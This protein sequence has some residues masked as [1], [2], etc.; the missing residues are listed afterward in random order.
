LLLVRPPP[1][2]A[3]PDADTNRLQFSASLGSYV[4]KIPEQPLSPPPRPPPRL[5]VRSGVRLHRRAEEVVADTFRHQRTNRRCPRVGLAAVS[6]AHLPSQFEMSYECLRWS[7]G[8]VPTEGIGWLL[9]DHGRSTS[10][11]TPNLD[12]RETLRHWPF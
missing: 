5:W 1:A 6:T 3:A 7:T 11:W 4:R 9:M 10:S 2:L 12:R 8:P